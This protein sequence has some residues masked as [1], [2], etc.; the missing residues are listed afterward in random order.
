MAF[1]SDADL[2]KLVP[3]ILSLG[4]TSFTLEHPKAQADIERDLRIKWWPR[5]RRS[6]DTEEMDNS[7]LTDSQFTQAASFLVLWMYVL[8]KLT[9]W[10][11]NDRFLEMIDFYKAR[12]GEEMEAVYG[13]GIEYD[14]DGDGTVTDLEKEFIGVNRLNR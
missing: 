1:S 13:D 9:N 5:K 8:P 7:K 3:D 6:G 14:L 4:I 10:V 12:Y 11:D 2:I